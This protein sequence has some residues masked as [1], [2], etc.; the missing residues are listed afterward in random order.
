MCIGQHFVTILRNHLNKVD[1][2]LFLKKVLF[3]PRLVNMF[4]CHSTTSM[5]GRD[6]SL[7][8]RFTLCRIIFSIR[9]LRNTLEYELNKSKLNCN[10]YY[11]NILNSRSV[12]GCNFFFTKMQNNFHKFVIYFFQPSTLH[13]AYSMSCR[14]YTPSIHFKILLSS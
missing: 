5:S 13:N 7:R 14:V 10:E 11:L 9:P 12:G 1:L 3:Q 2:R 8:L 4:T 6:Q